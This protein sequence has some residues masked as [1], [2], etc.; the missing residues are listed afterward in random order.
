MDEGSHHRQIF[1]SHV[2]QNTKS[3][4]LVRIRRNPPDATA[5]LLAVLRIGLAVR[6]TNQLPPLTTNDYFSQAPLDATRSGARP[7]PGAMPTARRGHAILPVRFSRLLLRHSR[8][9]GNPNLPWR[10]IVLPPPRP[11]VSAK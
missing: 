4:R 8:A 3:N 9:G 1:I 2:N 6:I 11:S 5:N 10:P 7:V